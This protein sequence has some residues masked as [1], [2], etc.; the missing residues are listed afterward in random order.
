MTISRRSHWRLSPV[1]LLS[2]LVMFSAQYPV[3]IDQ[4]LNTV[5]AMRD[6]VHLSTHIFR[7]LGA[8][9]FPA[10]LVRTPYG[11]GQEL[12]PGYESFLAHG[13]AVVVQDVRG[14]YASEGNFAPMTQEVDDGDDTINWIARQSWS[15]G[16]VVM[17]GGSYLGIVQWKAALSR[18]PHL[19]AISP[20]V[21][22]D[23]DYRDRFYST[24]GALKLG[25]RL[26]WLSEN[27]RVPEYHVPDFSKFVRHLPLRSADRATTGQSVGIFQQALDH[28]TYDNYWKSV[29]TRE[30]I[31]KVQVPALIVGGWY[32]NYVE[33]DIDAFTRLHKQQPATRLVIGAWPHNMSTKFPGIDFGPHSMAPIRRYQLDLF[34]SLAKTTPVA[35]PAAAPVHLFVMGINEWRDEQEW[36][37]AR[38]RTTPFYLNSHGQANS[39]NGDGSLADRQDR[40][41]EADVFTYD[42]GN[43]VPTT[44]GAVCCTPAIFPWGP[45]DQRK[46]EQRRDVLVYSTKPLEHD[47]EVTGPVQANLWISTSAEDTDFTA[48]LVDV[49]PSGEARL[50]TDGI[51]RLRYRDSLE[52]PAK[53]VPNQPYPITVDVGPTSNVFRAGHRIRVEISSSNFPRFDRNLN[54]GR[55]ISNDAKYLSAKQTVL[56]D[57]KHPSVILL[58]IVPKD[59]SLRA[60]AA[61]QHS[62]R[63]DP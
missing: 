56:H 43:P 60:A 38:A 9:R 51:L 6:G 26:L 58:P 21:S 24:G 34:D 62:S 57:K 53:A 28:P 41:Q 35:A 49:F 30:Q 15:N 45:L 5:V 54:T 17:S 14:R 61:G 19:K 8:G 33:S 44:G 46:V 36:P 13:Y 52:H 63:R 10:V 18:N 48:K 1:G 55:S 11:K 20:V 4:T 23:D 3:P 2:A 27:L 40:G 42:P 31:G 25:H 16:R 50:L 29:S 47:V 59:V 32:D 39:S 7:P 12:L 22:G 37:L